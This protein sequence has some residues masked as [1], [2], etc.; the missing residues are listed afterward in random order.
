MNVGSL[1]LICS[2]PNIVLRQSALD[3]VDM[4]HIQYINSYANNS[5][6]MNRL[7]MHKGCQR[8]TYSGKVNI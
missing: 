5:Q 3:K 6:Q 8:V 1:V 7:K 4:T 2:D